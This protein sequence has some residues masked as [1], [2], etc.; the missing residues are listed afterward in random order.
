MSVFEQH[1]HVHVHATNYSAKQLFFELMMIG[2]AL[3]LL[4]VLILRLLRS[5]LPSWE[6]GENP[7]IQFEVVQHLFKVLGE[8]LVLCS[9]PF[10]SQ[11][12]R[13]KAKSHTALVASSSSTIAEEIVVILR[14]LH[15]LPAWNKIINSFIGSS[16]QSV[17][18]LV[19]LSEESSQR[20]NFIEISKEQQV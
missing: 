4:Q 14:R 20:D 3:H 17:P 2:F 18:R 6:T 10:S 9:S 11:K 15:P 12:K 8:T 13:K 1:I 19:A 7:E 5:I 16:L